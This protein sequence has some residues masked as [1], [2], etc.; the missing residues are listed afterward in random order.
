ME[1]NLDKN[2]KYLIGVSGGPDSMALL[3]MSRENGLNV[4]V[5]HVNFSKGYIVLC[6]DNYISS[7]TH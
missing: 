6:F 5:C 1:L 3:D 7:L 4:V 2:K